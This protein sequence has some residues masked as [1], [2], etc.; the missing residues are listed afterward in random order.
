MIENAWRA[1]QR[2]MSCD[3]KPSDTQLPVGWRTYA[4]RVR[5]VGSRHDFVVV[6]GAYLMAWGKDETGEK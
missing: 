4:F 3:R 5:L 2:V 6:M 1:L